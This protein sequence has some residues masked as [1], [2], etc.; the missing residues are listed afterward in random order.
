MEVEQICAT[1]VC[2]IDVLELVLD[3]LIGIEI[4][5]IRRRELQMDVLE[6]ADQRPDHYLKVLIP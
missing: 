3:G 6:I 4:G 1:D 5:R 2:Q